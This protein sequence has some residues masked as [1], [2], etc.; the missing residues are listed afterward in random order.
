MK[1]SKKRNHAIIVLIVLL[2]AIAVGYAAYSTTLTIN[3][4]ATG[5]ATWDVK[6]TAASL[7]DSSGN[8]DTNHGTVS[9]TDSTVTA[10]GITLSYPGDG[11]K[12]RTVITN[13]GTLN[14]KLTSI[15]V[16]T[17]AAN[18]GIIVTP[19]VPTQNEVIA[20]NGTCTS[21]FFV[22]WDPNSKLQSTSGNFTV[23]FTYEQ[24]TNTI[25]ITPS[26]TDA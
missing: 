5:T 3:G 15:N 14:A 20:P 8:A 18:T 9:F 26:H 24:D 6:F 17:P 19:A 7:L 16:N 22:Q 25:N 4:T 11:V 13:A 1:R 12:L 21:E 10:T 2:I 23:T